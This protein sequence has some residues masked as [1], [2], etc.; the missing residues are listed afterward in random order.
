M[1]EASRIIDFLAMSVGRQVP[2]K[3][4]VYLAGGRF[5]SFDP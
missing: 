2:F 3:P 1:A 4:L 5:G